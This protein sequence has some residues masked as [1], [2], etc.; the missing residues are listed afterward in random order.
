[1]GG[2]PAL[3]RPAAWRKIRPFVGAFYAEQQA[4]CNIMRR[5]TAQ[6]I[7]RRIPQSS[8]LRQRLETL[9]IR[10]HARAG[11]RI[12]PTHGVALPAKERER[13]ERYHAGERAAHDLTQ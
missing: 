12:V 4:S 7:T 1:M 6:G 11:Q 2:L 13:F 8:T 5:T 3:A 9:P 10:D